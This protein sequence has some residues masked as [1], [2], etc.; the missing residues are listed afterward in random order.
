[1]PRAIPRRRSQTQSRKTA[2]FR[3]LVLEHLESRQPLSFVVSEPARLM[4]P[5]LPPGTPVSFMT[6]INSQGA[7]VLL[8][9][10]YGPW[11]AASSDRNASSG[12]WSAPRN[13]GFGAYSG[14]AQFGPDENSIYFAYSGGTYRCFR[15][16]TSSTGWTQPFR[17]P[18][19]DN[20]PGGLTTFNGRRMM[21]VTLPACNYELAAVHYDAV[22]DTFSSLQSVASLNTPYN[23]YGG[24]LSSDDST[25]LF[26]FRPARR[27]RRNRCI[28][29]GLE[30]QNAVLGQHHEPGT[31]CEYGRR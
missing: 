17:V 12:Q 15:S 3:R 27:F 29:R 8:Q 28:L 10:W 1:M 6:D 9:T 21:F 25:V 11:A 2:N 31:Q 5:W 14:G 30:R 22:T 23:E 18:S 26:K 13:L 19:L 4:S 24:W 16:P 7:S 20:I